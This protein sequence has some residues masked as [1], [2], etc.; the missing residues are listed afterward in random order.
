[1]SRE[2]KCV[3]GGWDEGGT[4][5]FFTLLGRSLHDVQEEVSRVD[6]PGRRVSNRLKVWN[7]LV[8]GSKVADVTAREH[9]DLVKHV[10]HSRGRLVNGADNT[11]AKE[12]KLWSEWEQERGRGCGVPSGDFG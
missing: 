4:F 8:G 9:Q 3:L 2:T 10:E 11:A 12:G 1:M 7:G 6:V 5:S